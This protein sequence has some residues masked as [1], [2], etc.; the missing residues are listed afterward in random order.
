MKKYEVCCKDSSFMELL[1]ENRDKAASYVKEHIDELQRYSVNSATT[2]YGYAAELNVK[3]K[4]I[5]ILYNHQ[6]HGFIWIDLY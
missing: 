3:D 1:F 5:S 2:V 4:P 6:E